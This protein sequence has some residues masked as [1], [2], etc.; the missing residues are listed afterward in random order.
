L[1]RRVGASKAKEIF[2]LNRALSAEDCLRLGIVDQVHP[3]DQL[4]VAVDNLARELV[5]G[6]TSSYGRVKQLCDKAFSH[7]LKSHLDLE[8]Q[9]LVQSARSADCK[10]G[11]ASFIG[12]RVPNFVGS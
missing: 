2:M 10:E 11:I 9:L 4:T 6:P 12:R 5:N 3:A 7:D 8:H 1:T